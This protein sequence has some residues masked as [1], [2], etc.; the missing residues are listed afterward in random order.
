MFHETAKRAKEAAV[1]LNVFYVS[2]LL[3]H[4]PNKKLY[5]T[6]KQFH[7]KG[8]SG[9][10]ICCTVQCT[11]LPFYFYPCSYPL[12][13]IPT[14]TL[15]VSPHTPYALICTISLPYRPPSPPF[16][17]LLTHHVTYFT[18]KPSMLRSSFISVATPLRYRWTISLFIAGQ[19]IVKALKS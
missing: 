18:S 9:V 12:P 1:S 3:F 7:K 2:H 17:D 19:K 13:P 11:R 14:Q 4:K 16:S 6:K 10:A 8:E 15:Y 5:L